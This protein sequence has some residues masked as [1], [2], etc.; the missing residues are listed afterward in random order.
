MTL[1]LKDLFYLARKNKKRAC[2]FAPACQDMQAGW[3]AADP[4]VYVAVQMQR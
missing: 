2:I 1:W 3:G 4:R